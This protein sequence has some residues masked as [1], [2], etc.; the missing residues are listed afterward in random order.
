MAH[1]PKC[2]DLYGVRLLCKQV[3]GK[4]IDDALLYVQTRNSMQEGSEAFKS[5]ESMLDAL[6]TFFRE[7]PMMWEL[8]ANG[9]ISDIRKAIYPDIPPEY[10]VKIPLHLSELYLGK[11]VREECRKKN[12]LM[13]P[14]KNADTAQNKRHKSTSK[15]IKRPY[16]RKKI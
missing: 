4:A 7:S 8:S 2:S 11:A 14:T 1:R 10:R 9:L 16:T 13:L 3:I 15:T 12:L 5:Y 6:E